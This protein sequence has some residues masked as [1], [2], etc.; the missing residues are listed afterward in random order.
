MEAQYQSHDESARIL[1][2]PHRWD[3]SQAMGFRQYPKGRTEKEGEELRIWGI[4]Y[5]S[6]L[7]SQY[8]AERMS[9]QDA[10][11]M[12]NNR[13]L[14]EGF[15]DWSKVS[16]VTSYHSIEANTDRFLGFVREE[17]SI[18]MPHHE[19]DWIACTLTNPI[20]IGLSL[21]IEITTD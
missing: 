19:P 10:F 18:H 1:T 13:L 9:V 4:G 2:Y 15:P 3:H 21:K 20:N 12:V 8:I 14:K 5:L 6:Y 11:K 7:S 16:K 17:M